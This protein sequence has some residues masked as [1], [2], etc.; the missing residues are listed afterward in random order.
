VRK[1]LSELDLPTPKIIEENI[2]MGPIQSNIYKALKRRFINSKNPMIRDNAFFNQ[3]GKAVMSLLGAATNPG[4]L[5][6]GLIEDSY[7]GFHWP[8]KELKSSKS[9]MSLVEEYAAHEIS[10]KYEWILRFIAHAHKNN[11]KVLIWSTFVGNI[12]ALKKIL[13]NYNPAIIYGAITAEERKNELKRFQKTSSCNV[14]ITNPQ[15]LGEGISLHEECH[16]AVYLDRSYNAGQYL[17][18]LDRIHR[19]G[20]SKDTETNIYILKS[21]GTIDDLVA[22]RLN[23]KIDRLGQYLD[24]PGLKEASIPDDDL[25]LDIHT[26]LGM[27]SQDMDSLLSHL[28]NE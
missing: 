11:K 6:S 12:L 17:Q 10:P 14:L 21:V 1:T 4:L 5:L 13:K 28:E 8:P 18:S 15:T 20:L 2:S 7:L 23:F 25:I 3:K 26:A 27:N 16:T 24:D 9:L 22:T 19:L